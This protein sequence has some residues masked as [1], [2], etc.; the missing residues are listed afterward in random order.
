VLSICLAYAT[1]Q[2]YEFQEGTAV[3]VTYELQPIG[4]LHRLSLGVLHLEIMRYAYLEAI[5]I[6]ELVEI[7]LRAVS[8]GVAYAGNL[9]RVC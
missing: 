4:D 5:D 1:Y 6:V 9:P 7:G 2:E 3:I 8:A